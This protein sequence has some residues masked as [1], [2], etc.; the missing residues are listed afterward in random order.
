MLISIAMGYFFLEE[1]HPDLKKDADPFVYHAM[2]EQTP[3]ITAAG[4]NADPG[5]DL[6]QDSYGTF[7]EVEVP[8]KD[9]WRVNADGTSR[10]PSFTEKYSMTSKW[11]TWQ[12]AMLTMALGIFTY[13]S[14]CYDHLLPIFFQ[15]ERVDD[16]T[17]AST[18]LFHIPGGL[19]LSTKQVGI[20]MSI[21]GLIA[22]FIQAVVF[23]FA[24]ERLGIWRVFVIVTILHPL[25]YF[26]VPYLAALPENLLFT[27][28]YVCLTVRN[29]L[30][31]LAY[32]TLLILLKQASASP[33][34]LGRING[35]AASAGAACRT[36]APPVAGLLY[37]WGLDIGFTG[38]AHWG[39]GAVA[40]FGV[41]QLYFVPREKNDVSTV[42]SIVPGLPGTADEELPEDIIDVTVV[43]TD[44]NV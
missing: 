16:I 5:V 11:F 8:H 15:D 42:K 35:L 12:V 7:N 40:L 31:I 21:N 43:D 20:I 13:H 24:A 14:M 18:N 36:M 23:P 44:E 34:V 32:P 22:L 37:G 2:P 38:L 6:R 28:I 1:T 25:A 27:G 41:A 26:I 10:P 30:S 4:A 17:V 33:S 3:M 19:G 39:T 9:E 29:L